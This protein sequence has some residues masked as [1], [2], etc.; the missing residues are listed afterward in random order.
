MAIAAACHPRGQTE[1]DR[2]NL[3]YQRLKWG[4]E[5]YQ[6]G[7]VWHCAFSDGK[8]MKPEDGTEYQ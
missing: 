3:E 6:K 5:A 2:A 4:V 8:V 1:V 7:E